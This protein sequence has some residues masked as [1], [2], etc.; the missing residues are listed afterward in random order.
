[1]NDVY[2]RILKRRALG[3]LENAKDNFNRGE[4]DLVLFHIEQYLQLYLKYLLY[5]KVGVYPKTHS[6]IHLLKEVVKVYEDDELKE[7]YDKNLEP[8]NLLEDAYITSRYIPREYDRELAERM[9]EF[10]KRALEVLKW[11]EKRS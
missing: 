10:A 5:R 3:F 11:M 7:F 6:L 4:N 2:G 8:L 9:L 1:M